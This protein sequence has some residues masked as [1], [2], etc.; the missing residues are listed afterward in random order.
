MTTVRQFSP[1]GPC[2]TL[3][4]LTKDL[5]KSYRFNDHY[6]RTGIVRKGEFWSKVHIEPCP[7][8]LDHP[9]TQYPNGYM[10]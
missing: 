9:Q 5:P 6:G 1:C 3:G 10:D 4:T 8:C 7:S 2:L